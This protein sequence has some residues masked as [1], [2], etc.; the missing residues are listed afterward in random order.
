MHPC[1]NKG[2]CYCRDYFI[3]D[4]LILRIIQ[5][6]TSRMDACYLNILSYHGLSE[7][8]KY[9]LY[10]VESIQQSQ[11]QKHLS[12]TTRPHIYHIFLMSL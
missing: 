1:V 12:V 8:Q 11:N 2:K 6:K 7:K 10:L 9:I 5:E 4:V 3:L